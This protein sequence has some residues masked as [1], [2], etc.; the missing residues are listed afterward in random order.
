MD[1]SSGSGDNSGPQ[2]KKNPSIDV[3]DGKKPLASRNG[4]HSGVQGHGSRG[5]VKAAL[6]AHPGPSRHPLATNALSKVQPHPGGGDQPRQRAASA[7]PSRQVAPPA[8]SDGSKKQPARRI[9]PAGLD[10]LVHGLPMHPRVRDAAESAKVEKKPPSVPV[11]V[12]K[13]LLAKSKSLLSPSIPPPAKQPVEA[14]PRTRVTLK[15]PLPKFTAPVKK[16]AAK[17][18][19]I[20][21]SLRAAPVPAQSPSVASTSRGAAAAAPLSTTKS[22][23]ASSSR[24]PGVKKTPT[25]KSP[26]TFTGQHVR[27]DS[28]SEVTVGEDDRIFVA[29][30]TKEEHLQFFRRLIARETGYLTENSDKWEKFLP[31][32]AS[33]SSALD[34]VDATVISDEGAC[35]SF[36]R[37]ISL[38]SCWLL[39]CSIHGLFD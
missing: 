33:S 30:R 13:P 7:H 25:P 24:T 5:G 34:V 37:L 12:K 21:A 26:M 15:A 23:M 19:E 2:P 22:P 16:I 8:I 3:Q 11:A 6:P 14:A 32:A 31:A 35:V 20:P 27:P 9:S 38:F 39:G 29:D 36:L 10:R 17:P 4:L 1:S 28:D 18:A